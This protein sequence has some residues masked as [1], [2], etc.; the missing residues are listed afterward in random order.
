MVQRA[1]LF[2]VEYLRFDTAA[3][4]ATGELGIIVGISGHGL[5]TDFGMFFEKIDHLGTIL[6]K[7]ILSC[8]GR[9]PL[10]HLFPLERTVRVT[11]E[12]VLYP[13]MARALGLMAPV[14]DRSSVARTATVV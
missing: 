1:E 8:L 12:S 14:S 6:E 7:G 9:A 13:T 4:F 3:I 5:Q 11:L 2:A 10:D